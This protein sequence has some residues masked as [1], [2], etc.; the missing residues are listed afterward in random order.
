MENY[1][2]LKKILQYILLYYMDSSDKP[3]ISEQLSKEI[4][5]AGKEKV[6]EFLEWH[7]LLPLLPPNSE[8]DN[9]EC[10]SKVEEKN[11]CLL[12]LSY[13]IA[14][15]FK[16]EK[17]DFCFLKGIS[18]IIS[19]YDD[20]SHRSFSD[21][22]LFVAKKGLDKA[23]SVISSM[24]FEHG[25]VFQNCFIPATKSQI[26]FQRLYTHELYR[27][28]K[29]NN[30]IFYFV[31]INHLF[32]WNGHDRLSNQIKLED[33]GDG[34]TQIKKNNC[35]LPVLNDFYQFIHLCVHF[36]NEAMYFALEASYDCKDPHEI[37]LFR[38]FDICFMIKYKKLDI[39]V[40]AK[41]SSTMC[42]N[43]Q[44]SYVLSLIHYLFDDI[45]DLSGF[46]NYYDFT[47]ALIENKYYLKDGTKHEWPIS[48]MERIFDIE[49]RKDLFMSI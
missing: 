19:L 14:A 8:I 43:H 24:G 35:T 42:Y 11:R 37:R 10:R 18:L 4:Q 1:S 13:E 30:S 45:I 31:D 28:V 17:I 2:G 16:N 36:Y 32:S 20:I 21:I 34:I 6:T 44:I 40:I 23:E 39:D 7:R 41:I 33:V 22:D 48:L 9:T 46:S 49:K 38:L 26:K 5:V 27:F 25:D 47:I 29:Y 12:N 15:N 3:Q